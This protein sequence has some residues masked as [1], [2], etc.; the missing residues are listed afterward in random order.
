MS[1]FLTINGWDEFDGLVH[2]F[3]TSQAGLEG[4]DQVEDEKLEELKVASQQLAIS[5]A[6]ENCGLGFDKVLTVRQCHHENVLV[7]RDVDSLVPDVDSIYCDGII[8]NRSGMIFA[9]KTADCLPILV[10]DPENRV[11]GALHAGWRGSYRRILP[12]SLRRMEHEFGTRV[13][14]VRLAFGP[15]ARACCYEIG[16]EVASHFSR[17]GSRAL[18]ERNGATYLDFTEVN[19]LQAE[20]IGVLPGHMSRMDYCT[21]CNQDPRF[22]SWRR[23]SGRTG[24]LLNFIGLK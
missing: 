23:E 11:V 12:K 14:Q 20:S 3:S 13:D 9:V 18:S 19:M 5:A 24:R 4:F 16:E 8:S 1:A 10:F 7:V 17:Y 6:L 15:S 2:G 21:V 22:Y